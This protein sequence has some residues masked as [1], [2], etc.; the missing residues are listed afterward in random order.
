M[1]ST[2]PA[3]T[4]EQTHTDPKPRTPKYRGEK[5]KATKRKRTKTARQDPKKTPD[6]SYER[7]LKG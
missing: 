4:E 1:Y 7:A 3:N 2:A 6:P 5:R